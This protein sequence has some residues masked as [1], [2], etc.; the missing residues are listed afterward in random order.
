MDFGKQLVPWL[1]THKSQ[2]PKSTF[3]FLIALSK[4]LWARGFVNKQLTEPHSLAS[5]Q[6]ILLSKEA[7]TEL[8]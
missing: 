1:S 8:D 2:L 5:T 6:R 4:I 3:E 7:N